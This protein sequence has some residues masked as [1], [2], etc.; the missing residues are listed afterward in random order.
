MSEVDAVLR[1]IGKPMLQTFVI[2]V[3]LLNGMGITMDQTFCS[4]CKKPWL[5]GQTVCSCGGT[6]KTY[7]QTVAINSSTNVQVFWTLSQTAWE[8]NWPLIVVYAAIQFAFAA[9][10]YWTSG[11]SSV[12]W[13][14]FGSLV[15]TALGLFIVV[16]VLTKTRG[17]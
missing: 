9:A 2:D 14:I 16:K 5:S 4:K 8:K 13:S 15:S 7:N 12:G 1:R 11:W 6:A 17:P 3:M 10:S